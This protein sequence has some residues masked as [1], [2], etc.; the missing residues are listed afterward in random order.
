MSMFEK[1]A[2]FSVR[3]RWLIIIFWIVAVPVVTANFP[4]I[5]DVSQNN[6][7]DFLPKNSPTDSASQLE[8]QFL[9]KNAQS[10]TVIVA[11]RSSGQLT[12]T[13]E[14]TISRVEAEVQH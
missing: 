5:N 8:K 3:F 2:R 11:S 6:N 9:N 10:S 13:D 14:A 4:S 1:I 12:G 7:S